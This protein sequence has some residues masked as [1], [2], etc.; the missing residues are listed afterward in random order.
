MRVSILIYEGV[1][2]MD[3]AAFDANAARLPALLEPA[4]GR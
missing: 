2:A 4:Q 1:E 3:L